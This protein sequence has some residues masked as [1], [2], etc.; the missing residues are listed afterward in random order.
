MNILILGKKGEAIQQDLQK[1]LDD[2]WKIYNW[3]PGE[4]EVDLS[5]LLDKADIA[6]TGSDALIYGG[7]FKV[8]IFIKKPKTFTNTICWS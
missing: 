8:Y 5:N 6:I 4:S 1:N 3:N 2:S 7:I